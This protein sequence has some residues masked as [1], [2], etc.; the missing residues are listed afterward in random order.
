MSARKQ[1][2]N[3]IKKKIASTKRHKEKS[4]RRLGP[5]TIILEFIDEFEKLREE[6]K[7]NVVLFNAGLAG[8]STLLESR[9]MAIDPGIDIL[10][11]WNN[12]YNVED[13]KELRVDA[14]TLTWSKFYLKENPFSGKVTHIDIG[15]LF[16]EGFLD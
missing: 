14:I 16:L 2:E 10:V 8:L 11:H 13:W 9:L 6:V 1:V 4:A 5:K 12:E 15:G 3:L 7:D